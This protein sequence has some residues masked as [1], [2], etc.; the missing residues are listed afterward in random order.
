MRLEFTVNPR[1]IALT[2]GL[3]ALC[4]VTISLI[5]EYITSTLLDYDTHEYLID[6]ID[7]FSVNTE[8][9]IPTWFSVFLLFSAAILLTL[10]AI[11]K[12]RQQAPFARH[13]IVLAIIFFYLAL[14]E[15]AAIHEIFSSPLELAF[16]TTGY[17]YF[18]WLIVGVPLV[19]L[20]GVF[21]LRF[22]LHLPARTRT[23][24]ILAGSL[25]VGGAVIIEAISANHLSEVVEYTFSYL[26]IAT[27]EEFCEMLGIVV[28]IYALLRELVSQQLTV[29]L[30]AENVAAVEVIAPAASGPVPQ[31]WLPRLLLIASTTAIIGWMLLIVALNR[32]PVTAL[33][34]PPAMG[35]TAAFYESILKP[36]TP[37]SIFVIPLGSIFSP[38]DINSR[39]AA[40]T[41]LVNFEQVLVFTPASSG[42]SFALAGQHLPFDRDALAS[43]LR[44]AGETEFAIFETSAVRVMVGDA[45]PLVSTRP[46]G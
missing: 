32:Q 19:I 29:V 7:L 5:G 34:T 41:L 42:M 23:L 36:L 16:N 22:L 4:L 9:A 35:Y 46:T 44:S 1:K 2:L 40:A 24:F 3:I 43:A 33:S 37:D 18:A 28:F 31:V 14:D 27:L 13:W 25:Y 26:A 39:R 30:T 15:G 21:Y 8:Q 17:L 38:Q 45:Q 20:F 10:L 11:S 12:H 6:A